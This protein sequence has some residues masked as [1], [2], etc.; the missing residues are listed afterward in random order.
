MKC[1]FFVNDRSWLQASPMASTVRPWT[2]VIILQAPQ[3]YHSGTNPQCYHSGTNI[4][5]SRPMPPVGKK[6]YGSP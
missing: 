5:V 1:K 3:C 6:V 2:K 4:E